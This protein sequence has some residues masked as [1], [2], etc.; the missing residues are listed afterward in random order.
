MICTAQGIMVSVTALIAIG[1]SGG[2]LA[3][4]VSRG[5]D[6]APEMSYSV[7]GSFSYRV[8]ERKKEGGAEEHKPLF[9]DFEV[10]GDD[11]VWKVKVVCVGNTN[12]DSFVGAYDGTNLLQYPIFGSSYAG[13]M[14]VVRIETLAVPCAVTTAAGQYV[15]LAY[16]SSR[17]LRQITNNSILSFEEL[18]T[19]FGPRGRYEVPCRLIL[20][21]LAPH[22]PTQIQY[23]RTNL[24]V[25]INDD[26]TLRSL[27]LDPPFRSAGYMNAEYKSEAFTNVNG[28]SFPTKFEYRGYR[29]RL[30]AKTTNDLLCV[31]IVRGVVTNITASEQ[32]VDVSLP[33]RKVRISDLRFSVP[34][35]YSIDDGV[36]PATDSPLVTRA[37][38]RAVNQLERQREDLLRSIGPSER[39]L[40]NPPGQA[41]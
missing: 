25:G 19:P 13:S 32:R 6:Q 4:G 10:Q 17:Y 37:R 1:A 14:G 41:H 21:P 31:L 22:V 16:A 38:Q 39:G 7:K 3:P 28:L 24:P 8:F 36:I 29:P 23:V 27:E 34:A 40:N 35:L 30:N 12:F 26:G 11:Y 15:W 9:R 20:S 18:R 33:R 5:A 2:F